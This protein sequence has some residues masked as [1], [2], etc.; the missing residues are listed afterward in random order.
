MKYTL[1]V[2]YCVLGIGGEFFWRAE[3]PNCAGCITPCRMHNERVFRNGNRGC[4]GASPW[5]FGCRWRG[6]IEPIRTDLGHRQE[7][8]DVVLAATFKWSAACADAPSPHDADSTWPKQAEDTTR[9]KDNDA[10]SPHA[11]IA[12]HSS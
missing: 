6:R 10:T 1:H 7:Q 4:C 11:T 5:V 2:D 9:P 12:G 3:P 8:Q